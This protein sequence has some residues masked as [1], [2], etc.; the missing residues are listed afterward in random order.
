MR[1]GLPASGLGGARARASPVSRRY[2]SQQFPYLLAAENNCLPYSSR[3]FPSLSNSCWRRCHNNTRREAKAK[4]AVAS[5]SRGGPSFNNYN[6]HDAA[7]PRGAA[8]CASSQKKKRKKEKEPRRRSQKEGGR[9][10]GSVF[11]L[12][13]PLFSAR[14]RRH[15]GLKGRWQEAAA[16]AA[17]A[18]GEGP[19]RAAGA[20]GSAPDSPCPPAPLVR[21]SAGRSGAARG[22]VA[23]CQLRSGGIPPTV[24]RWGR[25]WKRRRRRGREGA[26]GAE[27]AAAAAAMRAQR[28]GEDAAVLLLLLLLLLLCRQPGRRLRLK[29]PLELLPLQFEGGGCESS[30]S[31]PAP[32]SG[33]P[34]ALHS[35]LAGPGD[36][37]SA[38]EGPKE[39][40][41]PSSPARLRQLLLSLW[42]RENCEG[43][44]VGNSPATSG[45]AEA[46]GEGGRSALSARVPAARLKEVTRAQD[47]PL[48][49]PRHSL[50]VWA[51]EEER[52]SGGGGGGGEA[53]T[54]SMPLCTSAWSTWHCWQG[55][56]AISGLPGVSLLIGPFNTG[57]SWISPPRSDSFL[58]VGR[59]LLL[60]KVGGRKKR[61]QGNSELNRRQRLVCW[62][63]S[64]AVCS[65]LACKNSLFCVIWGHQGTFKMSS[66]V[67]SDMVSS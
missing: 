3:E 48:N 20:E 2:V 41:K 55:S 7:R 59:L 32:H 11:P 45:P 8:L 5:L 67:P 23:S 52:Q 43:G 42:P 12:P 39:E 15:V 6:P 60:W 18:A 47:Y 1:V 4:A 53:S 50:L 62:K 25:P 17:A 27:G 51:G 10:V 49:H 44:G 37:A 14:R 9:G 31:L 54:Q 21:S 57:S 28:W 56:A 40:G 19:P 58:A 35:S 22:S 46:E 24:C 30:R 26:R 65:R 66:S 34:K 16:G 29:S 64:F 38:E 36:A 63:I 61:K 33:R 13:C